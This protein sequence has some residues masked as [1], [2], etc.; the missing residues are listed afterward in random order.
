VFVASINAVGVPLNGRG[1]VAPP[2]SLTSDPLGED[3]A[4]PLFASFTV[5]PTLANNYTWGRVGERYRVLGT[6]TRTV[7]TFT[8][9]A[10]SS[11][12]YAYIGNDFAEFGFQPGPNFFGF[13]FEGDSGLQYGWGILD[14]GDGPDG[15]TVRINYWEYGSEAAEGVHIAEPAGVLPSLALLGLGA[16]GIRQWRRKNGAPSGA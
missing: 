10:I 6:G 14:F 1:F 15:P 8:T 13:R 7:T 11:G 12:S 4:Q 9:G 5:G 2:A 16:A 3:D